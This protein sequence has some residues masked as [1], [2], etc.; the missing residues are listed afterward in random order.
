MDCLKNYIGLRHCSQ[1]PASGIYLNILPGMS[2]ELAD[3]IANSEQVSFVKVWEDVQDR[4]ILRLKNDIINNLLSEQK[5]DFRSIIYQTKKLFRSQRDAVSIPSNPEYRGVYFALPESRYISF[6]LNEVYLFS[7]E[8]VDVTTTLKVFDV[9]DSLEL[10]SEEIVIQPGLNVIKVGEIFDLKYQLIELFVGVDCTNIET[11]ETLNEYYNWYDSGDL[12][13]GNSCDIGAYGYLQLYPAILPIP[14]EATFSNIDRG[15]QGNGVVVGAEVLCSIDQFICE[16]I[17]HFQQSYLYILGAEMLLQKQ[18]S[19]VGSSR[20]NWF[21]STNLEQTDI[22][23]TEF[24]RRYVSNL[25]REIR[26]IPLKGESKCFTCEG[27]LEVFTGG[28]MP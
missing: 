12:A 10:Y 3:K 21:T 13:C 18:S 23:R 24:E 15:G 8:V 19:G 16:N 22:T 17:H 11:I 26:S 5:A 27:N 6:R 2:T 7:K 9:N 14:G 20:M 1:N 28:A 4:A 25:K